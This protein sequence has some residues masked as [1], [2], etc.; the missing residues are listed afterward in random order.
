MY[1]YIQMTI[2]NQ[3]H[4]MGMIHLFIPMNLLLMIEISVGQYI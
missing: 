4:Y 3:L 1:L 2:L